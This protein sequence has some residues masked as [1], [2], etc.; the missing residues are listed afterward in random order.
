MKPETLLPRPTILLV[1]DDPDTTSA[2]TGGLGSKFEIT[3]RAEPPCRGGECAT[4]LQHDFSALVLAHHLVS[5]SWLELMREVRRHD[6][7]LPIILLIE[8]GGYRDLLPVMNVGAC[9]FT[10]KPIEVDEL[11]TRLRLL[12][13]NRGQQEREILTYGGIEL[14]RSRHEVRVHGEHLRL[15]RLEHA[16]LER[17]LS[18]TEAVHTRVSLLRG[19][20]GLDFDPGTNVV[21]VHISNLRRKLR[22]MSAGAEIVTVRGVGFRLTIGAGEVG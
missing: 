9:D 4:V 13:R 19:V 3:V 20:W 12:M 2:V 18:R 6:D 15:T 21:D 16:L 14:D 1:E 8:S 5:E 7:T 22:G 17:F 11:E 10:R